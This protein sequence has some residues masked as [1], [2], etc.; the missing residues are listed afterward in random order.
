[1]FTFQIIIVLYSAVL[2]N[3]VDIF[4]RM[5]DIWTDRYTIYK[6]TDIQ[7]YKETERQRDKES[8]RHRDTETQRHGDAICNLHVCIL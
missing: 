3:R 6:N 8:Q 1:M 4:I 5:K 7:T 2:C